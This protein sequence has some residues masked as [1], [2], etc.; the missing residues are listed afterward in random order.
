MNNDELNKL[1]SD[2]KEDR[3]KKEENKEIKQSR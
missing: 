3:I 1:V 2:D